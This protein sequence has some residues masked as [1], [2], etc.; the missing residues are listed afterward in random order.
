MLK[1]GTNGGGKFGGATSDG[2]R[3]TSMY[4][5]KLQYSDNSRFQFVRMHYM[6]Q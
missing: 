1:I 4:Q 3:R 6:Y 2:R 5:Q